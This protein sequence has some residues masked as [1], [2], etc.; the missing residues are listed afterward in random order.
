MSTAV[1]REAFEDLAD[2]AD[3]ELALIDETSSPRQFAQ[4]L[5]WNAAYHR[6]AQGL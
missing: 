5:R 3:V 2:I 6:L 1:G 4:Q